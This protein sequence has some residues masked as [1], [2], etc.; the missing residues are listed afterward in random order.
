[1]LTILSGLARVE[2]VLLGAA[3]FLALFFIGRFFRRARGTGSRFRAMYRY[4]PAVASVAIGFYCLGLIAIFVPREYSFL[5]LTVPGVALLLGWN[6]ARDILSGVVLRFEGTVADGARLH[7][8]TPGGQVSGRVGRVG[9]RSFQLTTDTGE[10]AIVPFSS[11]STAIVRRVVESA[12]G[13]SGPDGSVAHRFLLTGR[14]I[15]RTKQENFRAALSTHMLNHPCAMPGR[16]PALRV[17]AAET[18]GGVNIE[19]VVYAL[20]TRHASFLETHARDYYSPDET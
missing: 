17:Q 13:R 5:W 4:Y 7:C 2:Y 9:L 12:S 16:P 1:M 19:V 8:E 20:N 14:E 3:L 15:P 6:M 10:Q 11:A 18:G